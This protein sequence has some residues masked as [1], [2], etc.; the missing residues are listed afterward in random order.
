MLADPK[1]M[2]PTLPPRH[3]PITA[4]RSPPQVHWVHAKP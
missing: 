1:R 2:L 3:R 4:H